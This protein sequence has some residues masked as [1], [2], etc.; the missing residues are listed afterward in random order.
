MSAVAAGPKDTIDI[1]RLG[2]F[3]SRY[4]NR[5]IGKL[6]FVQSSTTTGGLCKWAVV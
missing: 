2:K 4:K 1:N 3:C 6:R 5:V